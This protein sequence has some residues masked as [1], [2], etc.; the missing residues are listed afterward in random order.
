MDHW[1]Q[2]QWCMLSKVFWS[3]PQTANL[4]SPAWGE[5]VIRVQLTYCMHGSNVHLH[6]DP[7]QDITLLC[8]LSAS[9]GYPNK[10]TEIPKASAI[11]LEHHLCVP[12]W[13]YHCLCL[14]EAGVTKE[15]S[16][17][18]LK[19]N[20]SFLH[21]TMQKLHNF[22]TKSTTMWFTILGI[23]HSLNPVSGT[24]KQSN[25]KVNSLFSLSKLSLT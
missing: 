10:C 16:W 20:Q 11:T 13:D 2:V 5:F 23:S 4:A 3:L 18:L 7:Q 21:L 17:W 25:I 12:L 8:A 22:V 24:V 19:W 6:T 15:F 9:S 1:S 14:L